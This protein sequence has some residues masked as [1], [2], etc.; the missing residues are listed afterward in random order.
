[1]ALAVGGDVRNVASLDTAWVRGG[2][3]HNV[4]AREHGARMHARAPRLAVGVRLKDKALVRHR[5]HDHVGAHAVVGY[6]QRNAQVR[7]RLHPHGLRLRRRGREPL[8]GASDNA[9]ARQEAVPERAV[10]LCADALIEQP[11]VERA[12]ALVAIEHL[13]RRRDGEGVVQRGVVQRDR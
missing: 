12:E 7:P 1:M 6:L 4:A 9:A 11:Q 13:V 2:G 3:I 10:Q 8:R 5:G